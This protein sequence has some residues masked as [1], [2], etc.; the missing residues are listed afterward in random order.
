MPPNCTPACWTVLGTLETP[1]KLQLVL[2][3]EPTQ[4]NS[5]PLLGR[6]CVQIPGQGGMVWGCSY[7]FL[8]CSPLTGTASSPVSSLSEPHKW[9]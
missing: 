6:T 5:Y 1:T 9:H 4:G 3:G 8:S 2:L 7:L